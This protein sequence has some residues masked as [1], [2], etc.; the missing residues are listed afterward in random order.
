MSAE[1]LTSDLSSAQEHLKVAK[2]E[3]APLQ[4]STPL[5]TPPTSPSPVSAVLRP[6][7][8]AMASNEDTQG[9]PPPELPASKRKRSR[10]GLN[11]EPQSSQNGPG[12]LA[13]L[14]QSKKSDSD[15]N[16]L[17]TTM[18]DSQT[19]ART[20][21]PKENTLVTSAPSQK[22][23][24]SNQGA[25]K[26][27]SKSAKSSKAVKAAARKQ[28]EDAAI[29][30]DED[31]DGDEDSQNGSESSESSDLDL[32]EIALRPFDWA[33]LHKRHRNEMEALNREEQKVLEA[34]NH[35]ISVRFLLA[36]T[37]FAS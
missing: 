7:V 24:P 19:Q 12:D 26:P 30:D 4:S 3:F 2:E 1:G 32:P 9:M 35:L 20:Q 25:L 28:A 27:N 15:I 17:S 31:G 5:S 8:P 29:N 18:A 22:A 13:Q 6:T 33:D 10:D 11:V 34:F 16:S 23:P 36:C 14:A 37:W 21:W